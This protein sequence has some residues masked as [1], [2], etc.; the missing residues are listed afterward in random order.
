MLDKQM[1][2]DIS[3]PCSYYK[4]YKAKIKPKC[5]CRPC[6]EMWNSR[7]ALHVSELTAEQIAAIA[8]AEVPEGH[9]HLDEIM[10]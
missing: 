3:K 1:K 2:K 7:R 8:V 10:R 6:A 5:G 4:K 9:E